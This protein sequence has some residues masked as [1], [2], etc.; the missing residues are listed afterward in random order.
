MR[1]NAKTTAKTN[2]VIVAL[3]LVCA[4]LFSPAAT[5]LNASIHARW[6]VVVFLS[7]TCPIC[8]KYTPTLRAL[9][10]QYRSAGAEFVGIFPDP[11]TTNADIA[12][13][14]DQYPC[15]FA[16]QRD[17]ARTLA[18]RLEARTTPEVFVLSE[19]G[20][21]LYRGRIDN[22]FPSLG[23]RRTV[24][25]ERNLDDALRAIT[26]GSSPRTKQT[27]AVGCAIEYN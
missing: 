27:R 8:Q 2:G 16:L 10:E 6:R 7:D 1:T 12:T 19:Q 20:A 9:H 18:K 23:V 25:T 26:R 5:S 14:Q 17:S 24:V 3:A 22:E 4:L 13:F 11:F 21:V 15:G